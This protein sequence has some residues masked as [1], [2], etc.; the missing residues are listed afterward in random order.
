M[1]APGGN[2]PLDERSILTRLTQA[3]ARILKP[4]ANAE[5]TRFRQARLPGYETF[6][7]LE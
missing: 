6:R 2:Q 5:G 1:V 3:D 4:V 7:A